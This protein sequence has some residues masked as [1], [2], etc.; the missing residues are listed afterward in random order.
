LLLEYGYK[1]IFVSERLYNYV[2]FFW[3]SSIFVNDG[4]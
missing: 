1:I 3:G 4:L 2:M